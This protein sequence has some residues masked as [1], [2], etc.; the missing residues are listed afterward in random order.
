MAIGKFLKKVGGGIGQAVKGVSKGIGSVVKTIEK[1]ADVVKKIPIIGTAIETAYKAT[2]IKELVD[3]VRK[4]VKDI[5]RM[6]ERLGGDIQQLSMN[7]S[8]AGYQQVKSSIGG[9]T[10]MAENLYDKKPLLSSQ[11]A[12]IRN[13]MRR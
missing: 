4:P 8:R 12:G 11:V 1:G 3:T 13:Q 9:L 5:A 6:G 7:P 10:G 2:P